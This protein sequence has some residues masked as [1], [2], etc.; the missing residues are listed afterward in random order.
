MD[1]MDKI[2][3]KSIWRGDC[4]IWQ[5]AKDSYGY[6][7]IQVDGRR[8]QVHRVVWEAIN[9]PIA[10][11]MVIDHI[12]HTRD[13]VRPDHLR[14]VTRQANNEYKA[15]PYKNNSSGVRGVCWDSRQC[16]WKVQVCVRGKKHHGGYFDD[17]AKAARV[18]AE[19]RILLHENNEVDLTQF[20]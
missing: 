12:C 7:Q 8:K 10:D 16:K 1:I 9:G 11:G 6:G 20:I 3:R 19:M 15:G 13:C 2:A 18:A 4:G 5:G 17:L 14:E